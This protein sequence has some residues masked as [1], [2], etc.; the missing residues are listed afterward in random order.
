VTALDVWRDRY[1]GLGREMGFAVIDSL[2]YFHGH[3]HNY[4]HMTNPYYDRA[5]PTG[6]FSDCIHPNDRGHEIIA[7]LLDPVV[8]AQ[9]R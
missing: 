5:D 1:I 8:R 4:Q 9:L 7:K 2:G 6:W 3:G